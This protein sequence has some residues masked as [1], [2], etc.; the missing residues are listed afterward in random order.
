MTDEDLSVDRNDPMSRLIAYSGNQ[1]ATLSFYSCN[2]GMHFRAL[3]ESSENQQT[4]PCEC[5]G[6]VIF[7]GRV[8]SLWKSRKLD[9]L[10]NG[11]DTG[12]C[13]VNRSC[14]V[15]RKGD[16]RRDGRINHA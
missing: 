10:L 1:M 3:Q 13:V 8:T 12:D 11:V 6:M 7:H 15:A 5:G 16:I 4:Y 14:C 2:C 9:S